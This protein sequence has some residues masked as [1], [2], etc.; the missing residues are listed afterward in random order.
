M[1]CNVFRSGTQ[2]KKRVGKGKDLQGK[3]KIVI[4]MTRW[5]FSSSVGGMGHPYFPKLILH[6]CPKC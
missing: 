4:L 2:K 1:I 3:G 5:S 6:L